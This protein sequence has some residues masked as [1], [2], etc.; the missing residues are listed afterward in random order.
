MISRV[1]RQVQKL[2]LSAAQKVSF[3]SIGLALAAVGLVMFMPGGT[4]DRSSLTQI[5]PFIAAFFV[6]ESVVFNLE[7]RKQAHSFSITEAILVIAV[8]SLDPTSMVIAAPVGA[9]I[10]LVVVRRMTPL[11]VFF[12]LS[13]FAVEAAVV[14]FVVMAIS[15]ANT[16]TLASGSAA[17]LAVALADFVGATSVFSAIWIFEGR[18]RRR[19]AMDVYRAQ[20]MVTLIGGSFGVIG[21]GALEAG[22][23]TLVFLAVVG[24]ALVAIFRQHATVTSRYTGLQT[25]HD[26]SRTI[27]ND[28]DVDR[29]LVTAMTDVVD[30]IAATTVSVIV[31][32]DGSFGPPGVYRSVDRQLTHEPF[33][34]PSTVVAWMAVMTDEA[35]VRDVASVDSE[36]G[37]SLGV[38]DGQMVSMTLGL[39]DDESVIFVATKSAT[40]V[41]NFDKASADQ[42]GALIRQLSATLRNGLFVRLLDDASRRDEL[43]GLANRGEFISLVDAAPDRPMAVV[44]IGLRSFDE[45]NETLGHEAGDAMIMATA[46]QLDVAFSDIAYA[47]ARIN[48]G[49]F[50]VALPMSSIESVHTTIRGALSRF[51]AGSSVGELRLDMRCSAGVVAIADRSEADGATLVQRG[52][53]ALSDAKRAGQLIADYRPELDETQLRRVMLVAELR[54]AI[55]AQGFELWFQPKLD[56]QTGDVIGAEA[57]IRWIHKDLGFVPP[58]EFIGLAETTGLVGEI[59]SQVLEMAAAEARRWL[60]RGKPM[61]IAVNLSAHD[62]VDSRL[63]GRLSELL[64][65]HQIDVAHLG[66]ELTE[67][68]AVA[69]GTQITKTLERLRE[70]GFTLYVD[71]YGTGYSSLSYLR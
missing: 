54:E 52:D 31:F 14:A 5:L 24:A 7:I 37:Q 18:P 36:I 59:T 15:Q 33:E 35:V 13:K 51:A 4:A 34:T 1:R 68:A 38:F 2:S 19:Q 67:T 63:P 20:M 11:K 69:D 50:A 60:D 55:A 29:V 40:A 48:G 49:T 6:S 62:L 45:V 10:A 30:V 66:L 16:L 12:N 53:L 46:E 57:L 32:E 39:R 47:V 28:V 58:D 44:T 22:P 61:M 26:F 64:D 3:V 65:R 9:G 42:V 21:A 41:G 23:F 17:I 8:F 25:L 71:D 70:M 56:L 27:A 43:T